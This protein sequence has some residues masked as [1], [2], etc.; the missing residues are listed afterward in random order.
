MKSYFLIYI[1]VL[2]MCSPL[3]VLTV[4]DCSGFLSPVLSM[5]ESS[6]Q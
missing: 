3:F 1:P 4:T 2:E 6:V 5:H